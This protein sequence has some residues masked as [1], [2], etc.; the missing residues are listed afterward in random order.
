MKSITLSAVVTAL[1]STWLD[2]SG[3]MPIRDTRPPRIEPEPRIDTFYAPRQ[4]RGH[5]L[6]P[7]RRKR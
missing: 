7:G 4:E 2:D 5:P 6:N 1:A 3:S